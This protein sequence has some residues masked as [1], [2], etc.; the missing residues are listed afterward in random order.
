VR[1]DTATVDKS[2]P[3]RS[4]W[5][6][7]LD[8]RL[9]ALTTWMLLAIAIALN[10]ILQPTFFTRY[11]ITSNFATFVPLVLVAIAQTI[12]VVGGGLDL[13]LGAIVA[14]SSVLAV[15]IMGG[16]GD[17]I[18]LGFLTAVGAGAAC[19]LANGLI[20]SVLRLQPLIA[21]LATAS[22]F[23]G[24]TLVVLP[25]PGGSVPAFMTDAYRMDV[26]GV[27]VTVLA[28]VIAVALWLLLTRTRL[29]RHIYAV[30]GDPAAAFASLVPV[31]RVRAA[32]YVLAGAFSGLAAMSL[33][34]NAGS[35]DPFVGA[36][37]ALDSIAA[38]VVGGV[39]L[40]G[41][42]GGAIGAVVGAIVLAIASNVLFFFEVPTT[43][44]QLAYGL[45]IICALALSV[46]S[47]GKE[48]RR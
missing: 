44:R 26:A 24:L 3:L 7:V 11:S 10:A 9:Q 22:I 16:R 36:S 29:M 4:L 27:P 46:L 43:Y 39:A 42:R 35:G 23:S 32:S 33:L 37:I 41:G 21:T 17:H 14:L 25:K 45:V 13:S 1:A 8:M 47:P 12:V 28:V 5:D 34:A 15:T 20:V 6:R 19:G 18:W 30:G 40:R 2:A 38:V 48:A 31:T